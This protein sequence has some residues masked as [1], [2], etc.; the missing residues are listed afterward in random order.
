MIKVTKINESL[1]ISFKYDVDIISKIKSIPGRKYNPNSKSWDIPLYTM[2]ILLTLFDETEL[3]ISS[4]VDLDYE[5]PKYNFEYE[6]NTIN[7]NDLRVFAKWGLEML[8]DYFYQ[9]PASS[10]GKYHPRYAQGEEGLVRHTQAAVRIANELFNN[11]TI[12]QFNSYEKDI[13]RVSLLLHDG[14][15][16]GVDGSSHTVSTHPLEVVKFLEDKYYEVD[17]ESLPDEVIKVMEDDEWNY[18]SNCIKSHMG[19]WNT[20]YKT[21]EE[22]LPTPV[23]DM[24]KFVHLCDYLA[25]RKLLEVNFNAEG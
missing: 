21:G 24:E 25:S 5:K 1:N 16:H 12:Q 11:D 8:P 6:L 14:V 17:E 3:D 7:D 10:S 23:T 2:K 15:K 9:V 20:D 22:I 4:D 18:I 13:M 19:Q